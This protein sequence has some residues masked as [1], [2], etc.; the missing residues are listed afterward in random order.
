MT[1]FYDN[2]YATKQVSFN[3]IQ[4]DMVQFAFATKSWPGGGSS[5]QLHFFKPRQAQD[6][7][8]S[9]DNRIRKLAY[10]HRRSLS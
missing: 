9:R 4:R 1:A 5:G 2:I 3:I 8:I 10:M 6:L 7:L